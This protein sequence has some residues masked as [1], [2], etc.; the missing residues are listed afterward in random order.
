MT[1]IENASEFEIVQQCAELIDALPPEKRKQVMALLN[2]RFGTE[3]PRRPYT[4]PGK[5]YAMKRKPRS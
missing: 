1:A 3:A 5:R 2:T 4:A